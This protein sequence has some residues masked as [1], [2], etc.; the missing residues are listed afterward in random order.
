MYCPINYVLVLQRLLTA[1]RNG[2]TNRAG[3]D[4][5]H[6][7]PFAVTAPVIN[8]RRLFLAVLTALALIVPTGVADAQGGQQHSPKIDRA[9]GDALKNGAS[10]QNVIITLKPGH[11]AQMRELLRAHGDV[12]ESEHASIDALVVTLHSNDV[13]ELAG[14]DEV[15][16]LTLD[17]AVFAEGAAGAQNLRRFVVRSESRRGPIA[18]D[19][20]PAVS[21]GTSTL[22]ETLGLP[23]VATGSTPTGSAGVGVVIIDSGVSPS[24]NFNGRITGFY[25]FVR[26][27]GRSAVPYDDYGHGT[28]VAG[29]I[30]SSGILSNYDFQGIAPE[31]R[32]VVVKVL[33]G[34]GQGRTSDVIRALDFVV[35]NKAR[36]NA[37][38]INLSLGHPIFAPAVDDPLVQAVQKA[39]AAGFIVVTSAGNRG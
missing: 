23:R 24:A 7:R 25:D 34:T 38:I 17:S 14:R 35:A 15:A 11:R 6:G 10:T 9:L 30:G 1:G 16:A 20:A 8:S 27:G 3:A 2:V 26:G 39:T 18:N 22:R 31:V 37:Q 33:D 21:A 36:L 19:S 29:L 5:N 32:L 4:L 28:H 13:S 12:V